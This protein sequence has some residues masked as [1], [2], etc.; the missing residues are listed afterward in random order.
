MDDFVKTVE[1]DDDEEDEEEVG[2]RKKKAPI[3]RLQKAS[4][5]VDKKRTSPKKVRKLDDDDDDE[6]DPSSFKSRA[7]A[8][9]R[10]VSMKQREVTRDKFDLGDGHFMFVAPFTL[11]PKDKSKK[12]FTFE[13]LHIER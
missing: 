10:D 4:A 13:A 3:K 5:N 8:T 2:K 9:I 11:T 6:E 7:L 12:P 1:E